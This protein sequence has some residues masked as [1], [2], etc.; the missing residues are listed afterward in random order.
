MEE[1]KV[2]SVNI[3]LPS[4][5]LSEIIGETKNRSGKIVEYIIK[6]YMAEQEKRVLFNSI[7]KEK[8]ALSKFLT[9]NLP[10]YLKFPE[11]S[12]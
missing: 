9:D 4:W 11:N 7:N 10:Y 3:T 1:K 6:G 2:K 12:L 5:I 8:S